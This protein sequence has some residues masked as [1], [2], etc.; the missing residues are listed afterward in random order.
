VRTSPT[1]YP[2]KLTS[3]FDI[4]PLEDVQLQ[5]NAL[6]ASDPAASLYHREEWLE[7][8]R[9]AF[10]VHPLVAVVGDPESIDAVVVLRNG[11]VL[12][13]RWSARSINGQGGAV[14]LIYMS[15]AECWSQRAR[16]LDLSRTDFRSIGLARFKRQ[17]GADSMPLPYSYLPQIPA[18]TSAEHLSGLWAAVGSEVWRYL[19][20]SVTR[21]LGSLTYRYLA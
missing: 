1:A 14:H 8:L 4:L 3:D 11:D 20:L 12:H 2:T 19:P 5:R 10:A 17:L 13:A 21:A 6:I 9:R 15:I 18:V 7:V 16:I